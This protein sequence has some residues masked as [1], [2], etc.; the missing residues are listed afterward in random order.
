M[1]KIDKGAAGPNLLLDLLAGN[2]LAGVT[3]EQF[4]HSKGLRRTEED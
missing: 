4:E 3:S 2:Q 1:L